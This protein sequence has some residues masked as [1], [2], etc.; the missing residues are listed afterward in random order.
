MTWV[1]SDIEWFIATLVVRIDVEDDERTIVHRN[2]MLIRAND[3]ETA[4]QKAMELRPDKEIQYLNPQGKQ[5]TNSFMGIEELLPVY[6]GLEHDSELMWAEKIG[7]SEEEIQSLVQPREKLVDTSVPDVGDRPDYTSREVL[8]EA[9]KH[10]R[11]RSGSGNNGD[12]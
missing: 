2:S 9:Y 4:Y 8:E 7:L 10:I 6:D 12:P 5:V 3:L 1:P 11:K